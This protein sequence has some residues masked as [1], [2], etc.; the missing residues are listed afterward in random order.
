MVATERTSFRTYPEVT[1]ALRR[2]LGASLKDVK[3]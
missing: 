3:R 2:H 1:T